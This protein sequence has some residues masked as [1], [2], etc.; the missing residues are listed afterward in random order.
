MCLVDPC[1]V[2]LTLAKCR[3][4]SHSPPYLFYI[5]RFQLY[6][7]TAYFAEVPVPTGSD[8]SPSVSLSGSS[9]GAPLNYLKDLSSP[10][11]A[12]SRRTVEMLFPPNGE[13]SSTLHVM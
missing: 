9:L 5:D 11:H 10:A 13:P 1:P 12:G 4:G 7:S 6:Q 3:S 2:F 8:R